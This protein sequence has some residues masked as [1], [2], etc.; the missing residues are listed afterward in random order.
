MI[1]YREGASLLYERT[2]ADEPIKLC[3]LGALA[4]RKRAS[5]LNSATLQLHD[6][7]LHLPRMIKYE[8]FNE[9][10]LLK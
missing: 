2:H 1:A 5:P 9:A 3:T 6:N 10:E 8:S 4:A 7:M